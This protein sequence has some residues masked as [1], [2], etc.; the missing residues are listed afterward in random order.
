MTALVVAVGHRD[1][2]DDAVGHHVIARLELDPPPDC[3]ALHLSTPL[4]LLDVWDRHDVVVVVDAVRGTADPSDPAERV[5][6][7]EGTT[8]G[9]A[10][11]RQPASGSHDIGLGQTIDLAKALGRLPAR[12]VIVGIRGDAFGVVTQMTPAVAAAVPA[13]ER[14]VRDVLAT[15]AIRRG[16]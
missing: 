1:R 8:L 12:L 13:A 6:V 16:R 4:Q 11:A 10:N 7:V 9:F 14:A 2:G 3:V 15:P 5:S